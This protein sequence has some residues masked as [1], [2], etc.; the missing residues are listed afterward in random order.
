MFL[1]IRSLRSLL[2]MMF[3][4]S[5]PA[6][7]PVTTLDGAEQAKETSATIIASQ[8]GNLQMSPIR[9]PL[10]ILGWKQSGAVQRI[11]RDTIFDYMDG[12]GELYIGYRFRELEVREYESD[13]NGPILVEL[14]FM[15]S[16]DDAFGLLSLDWGGEVLDEAIGLSWSDFQVRQGVP[17][18]SASR[19]S[20]RVGQET[21]SQVGPGPAAGQWPS[22]LFGSGL[23][24]MRAGPVYA[25]MLAEQDTAATKQAIIELARITAKDA[26]KRAAPPPG[27]LHALPDAVADYTAASTGKAFFRSHL[28]LN[29]VYFL[30]TRDILELGRECEAASSEYRRQGAGADQRKPRLL[31]IKYASGET[32]V[33]ARQ[34][35]EQIYLAKP[36]RASES[37]E[38]RAGQAKTVEIED[39]WIGIGRSGAFLVIVFDCPD[40]ERA[41]KFLNQTGVLITKVENGKLEG[42]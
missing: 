40:D 22:A 19:T 38:W 17:T 28:V 3:V 16:T 5:W 18:T 39:G 30:A 26:M 11:S 1:R 15:E 7:R 13:K 41:R 6:V 4:F 9:L 2:S 27:I 32:A 42:K 21:A 24:R 34:V 20:E 29:S 14:Y 31:V 36:K 33:K 8:D 35:F 12:A 37:F 23:L 25:R 10:E